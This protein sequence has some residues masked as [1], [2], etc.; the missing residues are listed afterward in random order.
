MTPESTGLGVRK[1]PE[2]LIVDADRSAFPPTPPNPPR[3]QSPSW[4]RLLVYLDNQAR[5][6]E[7]G[8]VQASM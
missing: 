4:S 3:V 5:E 2:R 1:C 6:V 7:E 8:C